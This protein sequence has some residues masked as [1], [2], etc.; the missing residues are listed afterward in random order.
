MKTLTK[1]RGL[2]GGNGS[3]DGTPSS[4]AQRQHN[5]G[6]GGMNG[7]HAQW[8]SNAVARFNGGNGAE[9]QRCDNGAMAVQAGWMACSGWILK[10][11]EEEGTTQ[12]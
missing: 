1:E 9:T 6:A 4:M 11:E 10:E 3:G 12:Q 7:W 2:N 8:L 5:V